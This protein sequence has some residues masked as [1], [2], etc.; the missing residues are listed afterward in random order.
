EPAGLQSGLYQAALAQPDG[1][2]RGQQAL[3][4]DQRDLGRAA[5]RAVV[6]R[7]V[8][9]ENV[10]DMVRMIDEMDDMRPEFKPHDVAVR[11]G[12]VDAE[13]EHVM[14]ELEQ[15]ADERIDG[16]TGA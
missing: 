1:S 9:H 7:L 13:L 3:A 16:R 15:V 8:L 12:G 4:A 2:A 14:P 6:V 5:R 11:T 10:L